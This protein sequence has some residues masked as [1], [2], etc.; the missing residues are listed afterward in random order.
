MKHRRN[1]PRR[2]VRCVMCTPHRNGNSRSHAQL[3][4][5]DRRNLM[6][7]VD[8]KKWIKDPTC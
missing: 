8:E 5:R 4:A 6:R 7:V 3:N 2:H 1:R